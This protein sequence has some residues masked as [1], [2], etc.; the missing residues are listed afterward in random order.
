MS[1]SSEEDLRRNKRTKHFINNRW[2]DLESRIYTLE[3]VVL[4]L[5]FVSVGLFAW[6]VWLTINREAPVSISDL[7]QTNSTQGDY[8]HQT[9]PTREKRKPKS[10]VLVS[11]FLNNMEEPS[12]EII[13]FLN[14]CS[15]DFSLN[16]EFVNSL[17]SITS[18][19]KHLLI[20]KYL[21][22]ERLEEDINMKDVESLKDQFQ[23]TSVSML[24]VR[25]T[26]DVKQKSIGKQ[27][28]SFVDN[29]ME[30]TSMMECEE[31]KHKIMMI[32]KEYLLQSLL[33][34]L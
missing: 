20:P 4:V 8:L 12:D 7:C 15:I 28:E 34:L 33:K 19:V 25:K 1:S 30:L 27:M 22:T 14:R 10:I 21:T 24:L 11:R 5:S 13:D 18:H 3:K 2:H 32:D 17:S 6:N 23:I 26:D 16:I 29:H 31:R 9:E